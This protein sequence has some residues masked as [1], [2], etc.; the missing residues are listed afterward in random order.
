[1]VKIFIDPGHGGHDSGALGKYSKESDNVLK[2]ALALERLLRTQNYQVQLS[3]S[4][5]KFV[6]LS[7]RAHMANRWGADIFLSL[8]NNSAVNKMATGFETFIY[9]AIS[10][11]AAL[12]RTRKYQQS[13]H[14]TIIKN[15][16]LQDRGQK[17][18]NFAVLRETNMPAI[19][20]EYGFISNLE[21]ERILMAAIDEQ[22][23]ATY[24]GINHF[25]GAPTIAAQSKEQVNQTTFLSPT[26]QKDMKKLLQYAY[27]TK[28]FS[29]N[30]ITKLS[31]MTVDDA[32]QLIISYNARTV[33]K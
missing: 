30:H 28:I 9:H 24:Q 17:D 19:L 27:D 10:N 29:E 7:E 13:L 25:F 5:D 14:S 23:Y 26:A 1:M 18:A 12:N 31:T 22:A 2:V 20:I 32:L 8:H 6:E 16:A 11:V 4:T 15:I 33:T 3:R 21:D